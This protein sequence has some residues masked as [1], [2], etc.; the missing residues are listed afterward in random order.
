MLL[1]DAGRNRQSKAGATL[2]TLGGEKRIAESGQVLCFDAAALILDLEAKLSIPG[3]VSG[4]DADA[5]ISGIQSLARVDDQV[6]HYLFDS[7]GP[8]FK[9]G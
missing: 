1:N 6:D 3:T 8:A 5:L 9:A 4:L 7:L 2:L